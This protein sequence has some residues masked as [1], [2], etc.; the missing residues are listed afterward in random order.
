MSKIIIK[1]KELINDPKY[2]GSYYIDQ[3][4]RVWQKIDINN[5]VK[6]TRFDVYAHICKL[7]CIKPKT[8]IF[9]YYGYALINTN[10]FI[11]KLI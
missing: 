9:D 3:F 4:K 10:D 5:Y 6:P 8:Q 11:I 7:N 1:L 2:E